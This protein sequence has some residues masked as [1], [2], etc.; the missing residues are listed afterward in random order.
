MIKLKK[1]EM[2][3]INGGGVNFGIVIA[4]GSLVSFIVGIIDGYIRPI[5]CNGGES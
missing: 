5:K 3:T 4:I 1:D 2:K